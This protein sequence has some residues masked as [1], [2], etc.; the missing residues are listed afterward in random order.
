MCFA[1][2]LQ[3]FILSRHSVDILCEIS[4][5]N[6][7]RHITISICTLICRL[8]RVYEYIHIRISKNYLHLIEL[9]EI[10]KLIRKGVYHTTFSVVKYL[11]GIRFFLYI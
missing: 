1:E 11:S 9:V 4:T 6:C 8:R 2:H 10:L 5:T 7:W 3:N